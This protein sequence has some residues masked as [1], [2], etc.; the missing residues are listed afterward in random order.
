M[1]IERRTLLVAK[2][3]R[4]AAELTVLKEREGRVDP[5][6]TDVAIASAHH[7]LSEGLVSAAAA[8]EQVRADLAAVAEAQSREALLKEQHQQL[9]DAIQAKLDAARAGGGERDSGAS[10]SI[11]DSYNV[12]RKQNQVLQKKLVRDATSSYLS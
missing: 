3:E 4:Y 8:L 9:G 5:I 10:Q 6:D 11:R 1:T 12:L 2:A 7:E